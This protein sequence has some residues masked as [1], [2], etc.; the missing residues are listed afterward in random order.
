MFRQNGWYSVR[1]PWCHEEFDP[2]PNPDTAWRFFETQGA[3]SK[4]ESEGELGDVA[5]PGVTV[6]PRPTRLPPVSRFGLILEVRSHVEVLW[7]RPR[8][9]VV[10]GNGRAR[11][12]G[13]EGGEASCASEGPSSGSTMGRVVEE[14]SGG[15]STSSSASSSWSASPS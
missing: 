10:V 13:D 3:S 14:V 7:G 2:E 12:V 9:A 8:D 15:R 1:C 5:P 4:M 6:A 11:G